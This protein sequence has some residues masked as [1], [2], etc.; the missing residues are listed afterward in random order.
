MRSALCRRLPALMAAAFVLALQA[1]CW[2]YHPVTTRA[3]V[4]GMAIDKAPEGGYSVT[5]Q[6][7]QPAMMKASGGSPSGGAG[8]AGGGAAIGFFNYQDTGPTLLDALDKIQSR[9]DRALFFGHMRTIIFGEELAADGLLPIAEELVRSPQIDKLAWFMVARGV[10]PDALLSITHPQEKVPALFLNKI[11]DNAGIQ[12]MTVPVTL[13]EFYIRG[14]EPGFFEGLPTIEM[15]S[16]TA[17][18]GDA[19]AG[20]GTVARGFALFDNWRMVGRLSPE[21][22]RDL[23]FLKGRA[24]HVSITLPRERGGQYDEVR[25]LFGK[26]RIKP[27]LDPDGR[28]RFE[29]DVKVVGTVAEVAGS[30]TKLTS[31]DMFR[32]QGETERFLQERLRATMERLKESGADELGLGSRVFYRYP[33]LWDTLNWDEYYRTIPVEIKVRVRLRRKG[34]TT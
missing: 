28:V 32:V 27:V 31:A 18:S 15:S 25:N 29:I 7:P 5:I 10:R 14:W 26:A 20:P 33:R 24:K 19:G 12:D 21:E 34:L 13:F 2:D 4:L 30:Q 8:G 3:F 9:M 23:L 17:P 22:T 6:I 16:G 11:F 1:G